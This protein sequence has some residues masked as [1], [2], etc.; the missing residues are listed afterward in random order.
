MNIHP[1]DSGAPSRPERRSAFGAVGKARPPFAG[2][3]NPPRNIIPSVTVEVP[4]LDVHP[5]DTGAPG[6]PAGVGK[7]GATPIAMRF[8]KEAN[9]TELN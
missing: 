8:A 9:Q 6:V 3:Q 2:L 4:H 7:A 1:P 5:G